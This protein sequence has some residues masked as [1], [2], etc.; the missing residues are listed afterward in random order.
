VVLDVAD[1]D[2]MRADHQDLGFALLGA[3]PDEDRYDR[4]LRRIDRQVSLQVR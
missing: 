4:V 1:Q 2:P 3:G